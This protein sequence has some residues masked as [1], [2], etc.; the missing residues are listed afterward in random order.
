MKRQHAVVALD[1]GREGIFDNE[2]VHLFLS[3]LQGVKE[4][5]IVGVAEKSRSKAPPPALHTVELL[6]MASSRL[7][8]G[9]KQTMDVAERLYIEVLTHTHTH[10]HTLHTICH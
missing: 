10:S 2:V 7:H 6:R 3:L 8:M 4:G 1:W 9:P 5:R